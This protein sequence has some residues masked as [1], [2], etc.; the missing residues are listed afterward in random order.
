MADHPNICASFT[1]SASR[2]G[3]PSCMWSC[4]KDE[5]LKCHRGPSLELERLHEIRN[6]EWPTGLMQLMKGIV[7]RDIKPE[8]IFINTAVVMRRSS[9]SGLAKLQ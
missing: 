9:T 1:I 8:S 3:K 6:S 4:S 2:T 5:T 7:H